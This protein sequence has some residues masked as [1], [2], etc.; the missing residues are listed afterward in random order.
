MR[1]LLL[2]LF[3]L[4]VL[5]QAQIQTGTVLDETESPVPYA[6]V[7]LASNPKIGVQADIEG[8]FSLPV[9]TLPDTLVVSVL[10][11]LTHKIPLAKAR[12][13][14]NLTII[15]KSDEQVLEDVILVV[16][17]LTVDGSILALW[18][19]ITP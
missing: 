10:G 19:S 6:S 1:H 2:L 17:P 18:L 11:Y 8:K 3:V 13:L 12:L 14:P 7:W 15:L 16:K 9:K 4:P 5:L